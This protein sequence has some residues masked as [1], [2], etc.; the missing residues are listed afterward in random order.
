MIIGSPFAVK[1][2]DRFAREG[3]DDG[4]VCEPAYELRRR[5]YG[6]DALPYSYMGAPMYSIVTVEGHRPVGLW[7]APVKVVHVWYVMVGENLTALQ[8]IIREWR[9]LNP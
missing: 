7:V 8:D 4:V 9:R 1:K 3:G 6:K 5:T 2:F